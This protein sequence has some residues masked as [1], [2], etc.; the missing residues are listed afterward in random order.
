MNILN[1]FSRLLYTLFLF[2]ILISC[3][4]A[5]TNWDSFGEEITAGEFSPIES[6]SKSLDSEGR[7][8]KFTAEVADVCQNKGCWMTLKNENGQSIRVTFKDYSYFV[9]KDISGR[10]VIVEGIATV[11]ELDADVAKHYAEDAGEEWIEGE[12]SLRE[13]SVIASGVLVAKAD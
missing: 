13:I 10:Q 12:Q 7:Q 9:P 1:N 4:S 8:V 6:I 11:E 3:G 2:L 5:E